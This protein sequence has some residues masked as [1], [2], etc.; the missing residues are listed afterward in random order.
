MIASLWNSGASSSST[1]DTPNDA[2]H[3]PP[4]ASPAPEAPAP[5]APEA[6]TPDADLADTGVVGLGLPPPAT[7]NDESSTP[8]PEIAV[9]AVS[10]VPPA[11]PPKRPTLGRNS[12][13][14]VAPPAQA[15]PPTPNNPQQQPTDSLSL[16]QLKRIVADF[17]KAEPINYAYTYKETGSFEEEIDEWF[18]YGSSEQNRLNRARIQFGTRWRGFSQKSWT[19]ESREKKVDFVKRELASLATKKTEGAKRKAL[20]RMMHVALGVWDESAGL[21]KTLSLVADHEENNREGQPQTRSQATKTHVDSIKEGVQII[22]QSGGI[23]VIYEAMRFALDAIKDDSYKGERDAQAAQGV[24]DEIENYLTTMYMLVE[25]ARNWPDEMQTTKEKIVALEPSL[26]TYLLQTFSELRWDENLELPHSRLLKLFW[27]GILLTLGNLADVDTVKAA[28]AESLQAEGKKSEL[29]TAS[30]LD[31][32]IFRQEITS[33]YPA[34]IPPAPLLPLESGDVNL[35]PTLHT[36]QPR[37]IQNGIITMPPNATGGGSILHQPVH[38]ATPAPSP[39]PSPAI[40]GKAGKKQNYQTNQSFPFMYP[41]LDSSSSGAGGKGAAGLQSQ[42][43]GR[44]FE[45][46]E[47]PISILEAGELFAQRMKMTRAMRQLWDER[48][49]FLKSERGLGDDNDD[50][51]DLDKL[52]LD[53]DESDLEAVLMRRLEKLGLE[54][55][56]DDEDNDTHKHHNKIDTGPREVSDDI[57]KR[58]E[59]VEVFFESALPHLQSLTVVL[60]RAVLDNVT[61]LILQPT[62]QPAPNTNGLQT[63]FQSEVNLRAGV[64]AMQRRPPPQQPNQPNENQPPPFDVNSLSVDE[65][66]AYRQREITLKA[67]SGIVVILLKW[68]KVSHILKFEYFTQLLLDANYVP[69]VLKLFGHADVDKLVD[70]DCDRPPLSF[71]GYCNRTSKNSTSPSSSPIVPNGISKA[72]EAKL[73]SETDEDE[74][75]PPPIRR[76]RSPLS[77]VSTA[78]PTSG[79]RP[80][81]PPNLRTPS[82]IHSPPAPVDANGVKIPQPPSTNYSA[83]N[84]LS[85]INLLRCMHKI[86]HRKTHR[87]LLMVQYKSSVILKKSLKVPQSELRKYTLKLFKGQVP[88]CGRKWR[89]GNMKVITSVYLE[90]RPELRDEWLAGGEVERGVEES[91]AVEGACRAVVGWG[92]RRRYKN[93]LRGKDVGF[94]AE[95]DEAGGIRDYFRKELERMAYDGEVNVDDEE[96]WESENFP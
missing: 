66:E 96:E 49:A 89:Q 3:P 46:S 54:D 18:C 55:D 77:G 61:A 64:P 80:Q 34:Y 63:A 41:P 72:D 59:D 30:P 10:D 45:G 44:K 94:G 2:S 5:P 50:D 92:L 88:F 87:L 47:I 60:L 12:S 39:P 57:R 7:V 33:K 67:I 93:I 28:V 37:S 85:C 11:A 91:A 84:F 14:P 71:F 69:L 4:T 86:T 17:P 43:V 25:V 40:G 42:T 13:A 16:I 75:C 76:H 21:G 1:P 31:Y 48:E 58:L 82:A 38:I 26:L 79:P 6:A 22:T 65:V 95:E 56:D 70:T 20:M 51:L 68:F 24:S 62:N 83:R 35:Y 29:I 8:E 36:S 73:D 32:H 15:P 23:S 78:N 19:E 81:P 90:L 74:A 53:M 27:K 9:T 52:D